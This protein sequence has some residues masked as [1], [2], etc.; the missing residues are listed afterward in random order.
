MFKS[1]ITTFLAVVIVLIGAFYT[2]RAYYARQPQFQMKAPS[3]TENIDSDEFAEKWLGN[4]YNLNNNNNI[5]AFQAITEAKRAAIKADIMQLYTM[6]MA[7][8]AETDYF[9]DDFNDLGFHKNTD[10]YKISVGLYKDVFEIRAVGNLDKDEFID[11]FIMN[12]FGD[13]IVLQDDI[14]DSTYK[15]PKY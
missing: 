7:Y 2:L 1:F 3:I 4:P 11:I 9:T 15:R 5:N 12:E 8:Y 13:F 6:E 14:K 10:P